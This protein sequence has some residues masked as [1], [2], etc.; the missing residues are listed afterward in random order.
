MITIQL[1]TY[2]HINQI[3]LLNQKYLIG[4][5]NEM[6]KKSGFV[7]IAYTSDELKQIVDAKEIIIALDGQ[8]VI[9]YYLVGKKS[10]KVEL[11][12]Q[13]NYALSLFDTYQLQFDK[14]GY[15]CQV[16]IDEKYR[17]IDLYKELLLSLSKIVKTKYDYFLGVISPENKTSLNTNLNLGW[18]SLNDFTN[19][20][21][22]KIQ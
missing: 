15:A 13:K 11:K 22:Y 6:Q 7:R 19:F 10:N 9:G 8:F 14:I 2:E 17:N 3:I 20:Y 18:K 4:H 16:C 21:L 12:N 1:P 5:L